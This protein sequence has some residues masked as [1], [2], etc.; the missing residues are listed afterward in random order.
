MVG[1]LQ[2]GIYPDIPSDDYV[3]DRLCLQ[4]TLSSSIARV[5]IDRSP[6]HARHAHPR[7]NPQPREFSRVANFGSAVHAMVFGGAH[8]VTINAD[9][10]TTKLAREQRDAVL[11]DGNI[12][13]LREEA[14]RASDVSHV[15][16]RAMIELTSKPLDYEHTVIFKMAGHAWCRSRPDAISHDRRTLVDLKV[17]GTNARDCNRQFFSQGYDMQAAFM[18]RAADSL[19]LDGIGKREIFYLFVESEPPF[20]YSF[21]DVSEGTLQIARK[22]V[23][24]AINLWSRCM[25][26]D[27]WPSYQSSR[28]L[29]SRPTYEETAWLIREEDDANIDVEFPR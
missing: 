19:D 12:P 29:T 3:Q 28:T 1:D 18:E 21:L 23:N 11:T 27:S 17:T 4:P 20:G 2:P 13:L 8:V 9:A 7:F 25:E 5:L 10:Y 24:A 16:T 26:Q 14:D 15:V 6:A 22:K